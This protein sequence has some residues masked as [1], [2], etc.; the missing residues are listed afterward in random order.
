MDKVTDFDL[1][2]F[3]GLCV[4]RGEIKRENLSISFKY[5][6]SKI[7][8][9]PRCDADLAS[10]IREYIID[11]TDLK[12]KLEHFLQVTVSMSRS[13]NEFSLSIPLLDGSLSQ[14]LII[15]ILKT[16]NFSFKTAKI[17][18]AIKSSSPDIK[19][20][21]LMGIAD[22]CSCPTY[23]DRNQTNKCRICIDVSFENWELPIQ[24]CK[25]LQ[26][27][28]NIKV[29]NILWGH[30]NLRTPKNPNSQAWKKEHRIRIFAEEFSSVGFRFDFK[31]DILKTFLSWN[32][33]RGVSSIKF[34][35]VDKANQTK[36]PKPSHP[37]ES[38]TSIPEPA[39]QHIDSFRDICQAMGCC[40]VQR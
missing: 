39:R 17:P 11:M 7:R 15:S 1:A 34:C 25:M 29:D 33:E 13:S 9:P 16:H 8:L 31:R 2:Y 36:N 10:K 4:I 14:K 30:P 35:W 37:S 12:I 23:A 28:L 38:D 21:F 5:R 6:S 26:E 18:E 19:R 3:L 32:K 24:I 20:H 27:D 22:A 40:Q